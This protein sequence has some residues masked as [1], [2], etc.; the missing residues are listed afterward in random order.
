MVL[1][2]F[3]VKYLRTFEQIPLTTKRVKLLFSNIN[4]EGRSFVVVT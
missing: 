2:I 1:L 3:E 4:P